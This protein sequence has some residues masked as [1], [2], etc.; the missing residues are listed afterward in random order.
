[1]PDTPPIRSLDEL[2]QTIAT[3]PEADADAIAAV[4]RRE[5]QLTKP[6]GSLG[7]LEQI[8]EWLAGW[9]GRHPPLLGEGRKGEMKVRQDFRFQVVNADASAAGGYA[10]PIEATAQKDA[11]ETDEV[12]VRKPDRPAKTAKSFVKI[13]G[14]KRG[15]S[16][17][18]LR[19]AR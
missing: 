9:Q 12:G 1:M 15:F 16:N 2:R 4:R 11:H 10:F 17:K 7:R 19:A 13:L 3:L 6:P 14:N 8:T 18:V 5:P